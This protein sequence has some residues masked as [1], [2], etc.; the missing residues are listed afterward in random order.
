MENSPRLFRPFF[1]CH[2]LWKCVVTGSKTT[3]ISILMDYFCCCFVE[4]TQS[5]G[6]WC[7]NWEIFP[8]WR[9][10]KRWMESKWAVKNVPFESDG[11]FRIGRNWIESP[12]CQ[13]NVFPNVLSLFQGK[14]P[15]GFKK[16][17]FSTRL[18]FSNQKKLNRLSPMWKW[19]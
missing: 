1:F 14:G 17:W 11:I 6:I 4:E 9:R 16:L 3:R 2:F 12:W 15:N 13:N 8:I 7:E 18:D 10:I 5:K 19:Q